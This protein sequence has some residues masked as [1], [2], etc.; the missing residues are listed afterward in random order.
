VEQI[1]EPDVRPIATN[2]ALTSYGSD[3]YFIIIIAKKT[4]FSG[5]SK[6]SWPIGTGFGLPLKGTAL[7]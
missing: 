2:N 7:L 1:I 3:E 6:E 5:M 4:G